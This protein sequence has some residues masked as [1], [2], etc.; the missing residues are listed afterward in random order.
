MVLI[1]S[2][3]FDPVTNDVIDWLVSFSAQY[4]RVN[5][6]DDTE[7]RVSINYSDSSIQ[8]EY[9]FIHNDNKIKFSDLTA[10][11]YRRGGFPRTNDYTKYS[12][13]N[14]EGNAPTELIKC[15]REENWALLNSMYKKLV[16]LPNVNILG[17]RETGTMNKLDVLDLANGC[18]LRVPRYTVCNNKTEAIRFFEK[19]SGKVIVKAIHEN[20]LFYDDRDR[21]FMSFVERISLEDI[22]KKEEFFSPSL[23]QEEI[24]KNIEIRTFFL[25][26]KFYSMAIFS[27]LDE[28]TVVDFRVYNEE[29]PNRTVP[30]ILP[31]EIEDSLLDLMKELNLETASIDIIYGNDGSYYFLEANPVGQFGM[32][33]FPCNYNLEQK[34]AHYLVYGK[35]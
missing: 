10:V 34:I 31:K 1:L 11:W 8:P 18:G 27:Q 20:P 22:Q 29:R 14:L 6:D 28:Q 5:L 30:Y 33:S 3:N 17:R 21:V 13:K 12:F 7:F 26:D 4:Y 35:N 32:T 2:E 19:C 23:L 24:E 25:V 15:L 16:R 9:S